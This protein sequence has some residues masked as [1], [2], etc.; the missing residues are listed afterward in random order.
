MPQNITAEQIRQI[1][2][3][4]SSACTFLTEEEAWGVI[5]HPD[6]SRMLGAL[7]AQAARVF[8]INLP[9]SKAVR[10]LIDSGG[11]NEE[12]ARQFVDNMRLLARSHG[13]PNKISIFT[14]V[15]PGCDFKR[16]ILTMGPVD[17]VEDIRKMK[18]RDAPT[19]RCLL[20][21]IPTPLIYSARRNSSEQTAIIR[22]L[23]FKTRM[24]S[25]CRVSFGSVTHVA[26]LAFAYL[27]ATGTNPFNH[28]VVRTDTYGPNSHKLTLGWHRGKLYCARGGGRSNTSSDLAVFAVGTIK[29]LTP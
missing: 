4:V 16:D 7:L 17:G 21:W 5:E 9:D 6:F 15:R 10:W 26:G 3:I 18:M 23:I 12:E 1:M 22:S 8:F 14:E 27:N 19:E 28:F 20:F 13:V 25:W 29:A 11:R 24:P 2:H